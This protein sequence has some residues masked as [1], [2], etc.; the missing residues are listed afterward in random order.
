MVNILK[1]LPIDV[2]MVCCRPVQQ[3]N[4]PCNDDE[5]CIS[6]NDIHLIEKVFIKL[7]LECLIYYALK[8]LL[9]KALLGESTRSGA[10]IGSN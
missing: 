10:Y 5:Q 3:L 6:E 9:I 7:L 1:E 4:S 8:S 2:T